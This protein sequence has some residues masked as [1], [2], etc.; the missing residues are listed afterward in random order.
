MIAAAWSVLGATSRRA[1]DIGRYIG[2]DPQ[3]AQI[4]GC[5]DSRPSLSTPSRGAFGRFNYKT[6]ATRFVLR[7]ESIL[8]NRVVE[9]V[10]GRL[11]VR[12]AQADHRVRQGGRIQVTGW[13]NPIN[14]PSNPGEHDFRPYLAAH[15]IRGQISLATRGNWRLI[16]PNAASIL[17]WCRQRI[18]Q[19]ARVSLRVGLDHSPQRIAFLDAILLGHREADLGELDGMFRDVG[20][21]HL[22]SISGAHLAILL[23]LVWLVCRCL[24]MEPRVA[25]IVVMVVLVLYL[26]A[27]PWRTPIV[28]AGIMAG[29]WSMGYAFGRP[30]RG[31]NVVSLAAVMVL[32]WR[33]SELFSAGFQLS[34]GVVLGLLL[35]T[36]SVS[37]WIWPGPLE[38]FQEHPLRLRLAHWLANYVAACLVAFLVALPIVAHHFRLVSPL[39]V[40]M[41]LVALPILIALLAL[42]YL[43]IL[44]GVV[45]PSMGHLLAWPVQWWADVMTGLVREVS[46]WS[47]ASVVLRH[48]PSAIWV[49]TVLAVVAGLFSGVFARRR[50]ALCGATGLCVAGLLMGDPATQT[51]VWGLHGQTEP[52][53]KLNMFSVGDGSCYL[54]RLGTP[55]RGMGQGLFNSVRHTLMFDCG[56]GG[57]MDVGSKSIVPALRHLGVGRIDTLVVSHADL[58]HFNGVLAVVDQVGVGRVLIPPQMLAA[59]A[60]SPRSAAGFLIDALRERGVEL[61][62]VN[63]GW[64]E[65]HGPARLEILWPSPG[66]TPPRV[67]DTSLV[68]SIRTAGRRL[69]LNGDIQQQAITT[70]LNRGVDLRADVCDLPHHGGFVDASTRW[71]KAVQPAVVLQSSGAWRLRQDPWI[72]LLY[73]FDIQR[74]AT[75]DRG[76]VEL[77]VSHDGR[78]NWA[79]FKNPPNDD[80][81]NSDTD[82]H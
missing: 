16:D 17:Q 64:G 70:M 40:I 48:S 51:F 50:V 32:I 44:V 54:V 2:T 56:S 30:V 61:R 74:L 53:L 27:V 46:A 34:F 43:K 41:S 25:A 63:A 5:V 80:T 19:A 14:G 81:D 67:N 36:G 58:D 65:T 1:D 62:A 77:T 28:R 60:Q 79:T 38:G 45:L 6:P 72:A 57:Y 76:M 22:L 3:L 12:L 4:T 8:V 29:L 35:F 15:E 33:P 71:L 24:P 42:G 13:L 18:S 66:L 10:S 73:E 23:G 37:R 9:P 82:V 68:L 49:Y 7:A 20:L 55:Y 31:L 39:A 11:W 47:W 69:V 75:A 26:L 52:A 21:A 59:A 78:I